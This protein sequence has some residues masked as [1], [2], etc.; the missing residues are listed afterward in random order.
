MDPANP[1]GV[2]NLPEVRSEIGSGSQGMERSDLVQRKQVGD[3]VVKDSKS[4][5]SVAEDKKSL[6]KYDVKVSTKDG[7]HTVAIQEEILTDSTPLWDDFVVGRFLDLAPHMA[8]VHMVVNKIWSYGELDSKV[9]V[10]EVNATTMRFRISNPKAQEKVLKR[11]MWNIVGVPMVVTKWSPKSEEE[12]QEENEIPMWVHLRKVPLHMYSWQGI[13]FMTSTVGFPDK[14]H[15]ET[16]ACTNMEVAKVFVNVDISKALPKEIEFSKDGKEFTVEFHYPWLPAKCSVCGK[17]GHTER[18]CIRN[19]KDKKKKEDTGSPKRDSNGEGMNKEE[20]K[21]ELN[22]KSPEKVMQKEVGTEV[23][24]GLSMDHTERSVSDWSAVPPDKVGR[25]SPGHVSE[26]QISASKFSVLTVEDHTEIE[27]EV[28]EGEILMEEQEYNE[29][30][31]I[32]IRDE[33]GRIDGD[34]LEDDI[35]EHQSRGKDKVGMK[36]G[37]KKGQKAKAQDANPAKST[38]P[39]RKKN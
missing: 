17:W 3:G 5:V 19:G 37:L 38:R 26:I 35:L 36:K 21:M 28:E 34:Q 27:K 20:E 16:L 18:V 33:E 31:R 1:P 6:K 11:G 4:W 22:M 39:S 8:K 12:K 24:E 23:E 25:A 29:E 14:L 32:E 15:P 9:D 10:Y 7:K 30:E 2:L 13:S